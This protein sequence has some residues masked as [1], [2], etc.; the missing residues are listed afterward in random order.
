MGEEGAERARR[1]ALVSTQPPSHRPVSSQAVA[2]PSHRHPRLLPSRR[3]HAMQPWARRKQSGQRGG[4][5]RRR[6][7]Q[8]VR[9]KAGEEADGLTMSRVGIFTHSYRNGV[10]LFLTN[11]VGPWA[12]DRCW[13]WSNKRLPVQGLLSLDTG[14][15]FWQAPL[16][17]TCR[18]PSEPKKRQ[19]L[20][21]QFDTYTHDAPRGGDHDL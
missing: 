10:L 15:R 17:S 11:T 2:V 20:V 21:A 18:G 4:L 13:R 7:L 3:S 12:A 6:S 5:R 8:V 19:G 16:T 1:S 9:S 14:L